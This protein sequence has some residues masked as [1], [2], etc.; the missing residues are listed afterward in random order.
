LIQ[1][2]IGDEKMELH[3]IIEDISGDL[4]KLAVFIGFIS[5]YLEESAGKDGAK[6][7]FEHAY[8]AAKLRSGSGAK[9]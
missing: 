3:E 5:G 6:I 7:I 1:I 2:V 9:T 8:E 4:Y